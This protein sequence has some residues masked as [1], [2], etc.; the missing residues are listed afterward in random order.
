MARRQVIPFTQLTVLLILLL[1]MISKQVHSQEQESYQSIQTDHIQ[2]D[3]DESGKAQVS[4]KDSEKER[5]WNWQNFRVGG[6]FGLSFGRH[7][8]IDLSPSLGYW[9]L[10]NRLQVGVSSKFIYQS[11]KFSNS[12]DKWKSFIYG[13]GLFT[14]VIAWKG[15][16][17]KAE[18]ELVN[19]ESYDSPYNRVNVPHLL[20]GAGFVQ[21]MGDF[22]NFYIAA[23]FDVIDSPESIY[24]YTF[25][26]VPLILRMGFGIG[27]PG[28]RRQR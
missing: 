18:F 2:S 28:N 4:S 7:T 20:L 3:D 17:A 6:N 12:V 16:F 25:G 26:D 15:L 13:G 1:C 19:K 9:V 14:D 22:G 21:P 23:M 10:P 24:S 11:V 5:K 27:F 8:Y